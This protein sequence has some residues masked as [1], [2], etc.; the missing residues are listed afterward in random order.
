MNSSLELTLR[1]LQQGLKTYK[2]YEVIVAM[3]SAQLSS[4]KALSRAKN[5][6]KPVREI[7]VRPEGHHHCD[8][9]VAQA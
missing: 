2:T 3:P 6:F 8:S 7:L 5:P 1:A 4:I 9:L